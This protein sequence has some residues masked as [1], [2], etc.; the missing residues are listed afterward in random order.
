MT[1]QWQCTLMVFNL[2]PSKKKLNIKSNLCLSN[3]MMNFVCFIDRFNLTC[4]PVWLWINM[5]VM[6][7]STICKQ[8]IWL[9]KFFL[10][11]QMEAMN[12]PGIT[13]KL[14]LRE[15]A[16]VWVSASQVE[17]TTHTSVTIQQSVWR[18]SSQAVRLQSTAAWRSTTSSW[19][20]MMFRLWMFPIQLP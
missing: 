11:R 7:E 18:K 6:L 1:L 17:P 13:K 3:I 10:Y 15:A 20:W 9:L 5:W 4:R 14:F 2:I 19:K 16:L 8:V 12:R